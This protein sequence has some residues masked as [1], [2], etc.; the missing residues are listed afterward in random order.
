[1][2]IR[3]SK[4]EWFD[5]ETGQPC[6]YTGRVNERFLPHDDGV[7]EYLD[8]SSRQGKWNNGQYLGCW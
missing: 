8:G 2:G 3:V 4:M 7:A 5:G 6:T 1:M